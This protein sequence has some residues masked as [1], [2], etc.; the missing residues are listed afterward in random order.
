[1]MRIE[2]AL[3][4][5][6]GFQLGLEDRKTVD[7]T[8]TSFRQPGMSNLPATYK[9]DEMRMRIRAQVPGLANA[10]DEEL[11]AWILKERTKLNQSITN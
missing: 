1:M 2:L 10:S 3:R 5:R 6:G 7:E 9:R 8:N 4:N 11:D